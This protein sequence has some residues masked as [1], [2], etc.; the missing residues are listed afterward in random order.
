MAWMPD[1]AGSVVN[2]LMPGMA[3]PEQLAALRTGHRQAAGHPVPA[4][5]RQHHLGG[6]HMAQ[7]AVDLSQQQERR[8]AGADAW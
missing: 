3:T 4:L 2:G 5:M 8:L 7:E 6:I 1:S